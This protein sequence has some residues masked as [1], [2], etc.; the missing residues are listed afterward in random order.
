MAL[1][2]RFRRLKRGLF[3][4]LALR[5]PKCAALPPTSTPLSLRRFDFA[6]A[7]ETS[8]R[9]LMLFLPGIGDMLEDF[10]FHGFIADVRERKIAAD[11]LVPG[12]HFG[13]YLRP[14]LIAR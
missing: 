7:Q 9:E 11:L 14:P 1:R 13:D 4:N 3:C 6:D 2:H 5:F 8:V 10:E 12:M